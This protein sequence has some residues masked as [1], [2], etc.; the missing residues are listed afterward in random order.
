MSDQHF[1]GCLC[2]RVR[3]MT[4][5][6]LRGVVYCHCS[7]CRKQTGHYLAAT[8]VPDENIVIEGADNLTWYAASDH[9]RR[10]FCKTCGT[11]MFWKRN[12]SDKVSVTAGTFAEPSGLVEECHIFVAD[13]GDYYTLTDGLPQFA[14]ST[15]KIPV[16]GD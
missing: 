8:D 7:Q 15:P 12:V 5:G 1:G 13:K 9:A 6:E 4:R 10:G 14:R 3:Y 16:A 11:L 2:G